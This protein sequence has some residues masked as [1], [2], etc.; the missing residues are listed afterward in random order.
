MS[1]P[2]ITAADFITYQVTDN[3]ATC[4]DCGTSNARKPAAPVLI[5]GKQYCLWCALG[6]AEALLSPNGQGRT[7]RIIFTLRQKRGVRV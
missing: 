3:P 5:K 4:A 1:K 7:E 2:R 6:I